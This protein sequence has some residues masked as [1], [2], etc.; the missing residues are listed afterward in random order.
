MSIAT[1]PR[2]AF[3]LVELL[4]VLSI[5]ALLVGILLP[6]LAS[7]RMYANRTACSANL[8]QVGIAVQSYTNQFAAKYPLA[9]YMP[10]PFV[11]GFP[12]DPGLPDAL[13]PF[14]DSAARKVYRCPGD[15]QVF[16]AAG[17]SYVYS[18]MLAGR[19]PEQSWMITRMGLNLT[20][21][22]I[23][24]D[25][26]GNTFT[27]TTGNISVPP[28]HDRRNILFADGHVGEFD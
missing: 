12:A 5:T 27:L 18:T 10:D 11:T 19:A 22:P 23:S 25:C 28:F 13:G 15:S 20:Q 26:D 7:V 6:A 1:R 16:A 24:Y 14:I 21:V 8:R 17:I 4:V 2:H 9:R 3:T